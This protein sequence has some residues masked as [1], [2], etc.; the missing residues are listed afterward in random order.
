MYQ[1]C[2][3]MQ[4][5]HSAADNVSLFTALHIRYHSL[6]FNQNGFDCR[7]VGW[8]VELFIA[9]QTGKAAELVIPQTQSLDHTN[10]VAGKV[11]CILNSGTKLVKRR[12]LDVVLG[13]GKMH[14]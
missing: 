4:G 11:K 1:V 3:R 5:I 7:F 12:G 8:P 2:I 6:F 10:V 13:G 14:A 9:P